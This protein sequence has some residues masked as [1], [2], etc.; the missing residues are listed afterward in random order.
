MHPSKPVD[1]SLET[2]APASLCTEP[3]RLWETPTL[4]AL[5]L[6]ETYN[7]PNFNSDGLSGS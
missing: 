7:A 4:D 3:K 6:S 5:P 2:Q 1:A